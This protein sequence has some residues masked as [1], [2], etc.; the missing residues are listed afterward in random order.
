MKRRDFV[1][2]A[3]A[4]GGALAVSPA[5]VLAQGG[6][7]GGRFSYVSGSRRVEGTIV[8]D[9][10][11]GNFSIKWQSGKESGTTR[12]RSNSKKYQQVAEAFAKTQALSLV[13]NGKAGRITLRDDLKSADMSFGGESGQVSTQALPAAVAIGV[14]GAGAF[15][16]GVVIGAGV[17]A[18][19]TALNEDSNVK[20]KF[21]AGGMSAEVEVDN[22]G[23][24]R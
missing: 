17:A 15:L 21:S 24:D 2:F 7:G 6:G 9:P 3:L 16:A 14:A 1:K 19:A 18:I 22:D 5:S 12:L 23:G 11:S 4:A 13:A 20:V 8:G 10:Q